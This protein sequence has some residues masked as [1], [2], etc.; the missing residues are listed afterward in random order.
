MIALFDVGMPISYICIQFL[1]SKQGS[2]VNADSAK[3]KNFLA[4]F[5]F[6]ILPQT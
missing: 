1:V 5:F 6:S 4:R 2:N 3:S